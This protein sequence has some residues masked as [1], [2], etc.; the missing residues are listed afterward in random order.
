LEVPTVIL[1]DFGFKPC[2]ERKL[3]VEVGPRHQLE[4]VK[5]WRKKLDITR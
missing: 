1:W 4:D 5:S 3:A 2:V